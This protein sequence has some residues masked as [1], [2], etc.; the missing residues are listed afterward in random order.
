MRLT[1]DKK[2]LILA[3]ARCRSGW[4][5][6]SLRDEIYTDMESFFE[7]N[8]ADREQHKF[9]DTWPPHTPNFIVS[10]QIKLDRQTYKKF[11]VVRNPWERFVSFYLRFRKPREQSATQYA[12]ETGD[13][14]I[15]NEHAMTELACQC[16]FEEFMIQI[17]LGNR[18]FEVGSIFNFLL[19]ERGTL[20][21]DHIF[22]FDDTEGIKKFFN[23]SGYKFND[24]GVGAPNR[25]WQKMHST[26]TRKIVATLCELDIRYFRFTFD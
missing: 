22:R 21:I 19:N 5:W 26:T 9:R 23:S 7:L 16:T 15:L 11:S 6:N 14:S 24:V 18:S 10:Q 13:K 3:P 4:I 20:D 12:K 1:R 8:R 17:A 25:D 2:L